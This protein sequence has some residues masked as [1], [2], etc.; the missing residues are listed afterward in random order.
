MQQTRKNRTQENLPTSLSP[1]VH[2]W[3]LA[4]DKF[5]LIANWLIDSYNAAG[6]LRGSEYDWPGRRRRRGGHCH[7]ES[8]RL[9]DGE[10]QWGFVEH[11]LDARPKRC[12]RSP[13]QHSR[14]T[15]EAVQQLE[16]Q[17]HLV[18]NHRSGNVPNSRRRCFH[19][20]VGQYNN[21]KYNNYYLQGGVKNWTPCVLLAN[22]FVNLPDIILMAFI[23]HKQYR[24]TKQI[25]LHVTSLT[26]L[27]DGKI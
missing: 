16:V 4:L 7:G 9:W 11:R 12:V 10:C 23:S 18:R 5:M 6:G 19:R 17:T 1:S 3:T 20:T 24:Q 21:L 22:Y 26:V 14:E 8:R 2:A 13:V 27:F 25:K 15:A